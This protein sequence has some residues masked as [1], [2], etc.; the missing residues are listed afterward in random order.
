MSSILLPPPSS[1]PSIA[2]PYFNMSIE[3]LA[4]L[5]M[6]SYNDFAN[7]LSNLNQESAHFKSTSNISSV[8]N[9]IDSLRT[10]NQNMNNQIYSN[11]YSMADKLLSSESILKLQE[12]KT[13]NRS[14]VKLLSSLERFTQNLKSDKLEQNFIETNLAVSIVD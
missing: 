4:R 9:A 10:K 8:V 3:E 5:P 13:S 6:N 12:V 7:V 2:H 11:I 1:S 14:I